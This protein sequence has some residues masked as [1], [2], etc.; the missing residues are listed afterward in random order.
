MQ[1][2]GGNDSP[3]RNSENYLG[4]SDVFHGNELPPAAYKHK[5]EKTRTLAKHSGSGDSW[6]AGGPGGVKLHEKQLH[7]QQLEDEN[8]NLRELSRSLMKERQDL[9]NNLNRWVW[10]SPHAV[11]L[12][13]ALSL[14][15][16][17]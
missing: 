10:G 6:D 3:E 13:V 16:P 14:Q 4:S 8:S 7:L 1:D 2:W 5:P 11:A 9:V 17:G 15:A 12:G